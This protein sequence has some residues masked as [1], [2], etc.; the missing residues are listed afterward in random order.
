MVQIIELR[1]GVIE[2]G[3]ITIESVWRD[4]GRERVSEQRRQ[5]EEGDPEILS[6]INA[7]G[8]VIGRCECKSVSVCVSPIK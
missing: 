7:H 4:K 3:E 6:W 2:K 1:E 8:G 5:N